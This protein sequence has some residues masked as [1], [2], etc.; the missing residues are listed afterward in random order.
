MNERELAAGLSP[1]PG[2]RYADRVGDRLFV[3]GQVPH[4]ARGDLV[5]RLDP[6]RQALQCLSNL[7]TVMATH[8]FERS[9]IRYL[10]IYVVGSGPNLSTAWNAVETWFD[11]DVPPATLLGV[12]RLGYADQLVEIDATVVRVSGNEPGEPHRNVDH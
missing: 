6:H 12:A 10:R 2:Y 3:A 5:G 7:H 11:H 8:G 9:D 1:T 4:D